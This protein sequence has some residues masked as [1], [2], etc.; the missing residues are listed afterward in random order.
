MAYVGWA[1]LARDPEVSRL[2]ALVEYLRAIED[3]KLEGGE[4]VFGLDTRTP[5]S[6]F[7]LL[8]TWPGSKVIPIEWTDDF[9]AARNQVIE[10]IES[11][12]TVALDPDEMPNA[13]LL[14]N[15]GYIVKRDMV[16][17]D[18]KSGYLMWFRNFFGGDNVRVPP[19]N[20][21]WHLRM[22]RTGRGKY[23]RK[24]HELVAID[25]KQESKTRNTGLIGRLP[26]ESFVIHAKPPTLL[27]S[28]TKL[29]EKMS[30]AAGIRNVM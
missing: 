11:P 19:L 9:S 25:G 21:D 12:W 7:D 20:S 14:N 17:P 22:W 24:I 4:F 26:V 30:R 10:Q 6:T 18:P 13:R 1:F 3:D 5:Q 29:Y 27:E 16:E 15:I 8:A 28:D 2:R 23:Y